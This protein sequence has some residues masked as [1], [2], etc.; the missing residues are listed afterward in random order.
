MN[1]LEIY[2]NFWIFAVLGW[3]MEI[4]VCSFGEKKIVNRGFLIGPYCPIYGFGA[5]IML[6][7]IPYKDDPF[8]CFVLSLFTCSILEYF[9]SYLMEKMFKIRWWDYSSDTFNING[10]V[11]LRNALAFGALGV[12]FTRYLYPV[13]S[14]LFTMLNDSTVLVLSIIVLIITT[15]D[16]IVSFKAMD[17]VKNIVRKNISEWQNKDATLDIKKL[18]HDKI[19][20]TNFFERRLLRT[21]HLLEEKHENLKNKIES[22]SKG[23]G[24]GVVLSS[25]IF[26]IIVGLILSYVFKL[27]HYSI[28]IPI[29]ISLCTLISSF[30]LKV[31]GK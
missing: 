26:G 16:I 18:I 22:L 10:R 24:Y 7:F 9:S 20:H 13:V 17:S 28:I 6:L 3:I 19:I 23:S 25:I 14:N 12:I 15:V 27:G 30:V 29:S 21:Y 8:T 5:S 2:L 31:R 1:I 4:I 11:C